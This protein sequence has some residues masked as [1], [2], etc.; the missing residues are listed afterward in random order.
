MHYIR[1]FD[2][3][4]SANMRYVYFVITWHEFYKRWI[5]LFDYGKQ[6]ERDL[7]FDEL[8]RVP[9]TWMG[10]YSFGIAWNGRWSERIQVLD[11]LFPPDDMFDARA[12]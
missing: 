2:H 12:E 11:T 8:Q 5:P 10:L 4:D 6:Q 7:M 9:G 3:F 1:K